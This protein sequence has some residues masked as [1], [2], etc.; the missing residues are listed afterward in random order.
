MEPSASR[1]VREEQGIKRAW[2]ARKKRNRFPQN[3]PEP[4]PSSVR[5]GAE[6]PRLAAPYLKMA[7]GASPGST[8]APRPQRCGDAAAAG[9][10]LGWGCLRKALPGGWESGLP[11]RLMLPSP[12]EA[13]R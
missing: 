6:R 11:P 10:R 12:P 13:G 2:K 3:A 8:Q 9:L 7:P 4:A 1:G 5:S